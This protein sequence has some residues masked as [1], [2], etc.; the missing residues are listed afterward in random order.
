[1]SRT[2]YAA[3]RS[4]GC[5]APF[6]VRRTPYKVKLFTLD[7]YIIKEYTGAREKV[8]LGSLPIAFLQSP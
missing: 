4:A 3:Y 5:I 1:M 2:K 8:R 7:S 6:H